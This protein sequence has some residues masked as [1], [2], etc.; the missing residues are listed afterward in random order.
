MAASRDRSGK[1]VTMPR[2]KKSSKD[3][4][5]TT[6]KVK[7]VNK[8]NSGKVSGIGLY[9]VSPDKKGKLREYMSDAR[10]KGATRKVR[11]NAQR[12]ELQAKGFSKRKSV[13][14]Y[15]TFRTHPLIRNAG[16][17]AAENKYRG[18]GGKPVPVKS[19]NKTPKTVARGAAF[20]KKPKSRISRGFGGFLGGSGG[21]LR[22]N[23]TK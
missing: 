9:A 1:K 21:G 17:P 18:A 11:D 14:K 13:L 16:E 4:K 5:I 22:S 8:A 15:D 2:G 3:N 12:A 23:V 19:K 20:G 10:V 7:A 6:G